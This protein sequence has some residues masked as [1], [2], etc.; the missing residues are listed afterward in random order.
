MNNLHNNSLTF[1]FTSDKGRPRVISINEMNPESVSP[2]EN[3]PLFKSAIVENATKILFFPMQ[4]QPCNL[5]DNIT[6]E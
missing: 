1:I 2:W 4:E 3:Y 6:Q 5:K